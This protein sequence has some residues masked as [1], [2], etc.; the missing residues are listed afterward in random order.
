[1]KGGREE[2][3]QAK[4]KRFP[5]L[6]SSYVISKTNLPL[7][8]SSSQSCYFNLPSAAIIG[9]HHQPGQKEQD[10]NPKVLS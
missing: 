1:M 3:R 9:M 6:S 5:K 7:N 2:G 8:P 10:R 4:Q